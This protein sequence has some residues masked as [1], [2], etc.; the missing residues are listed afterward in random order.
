VLGQKH[1]YVVLG[2]RASRRITQRCALKRKLEDSSLLLQ[3]RNGKGWHSSVE[4]DRITLLRLKLCFKGIWCQ[5]GILLSKTNRQK[6]KQ[7]FTGQGAISSA[8]PGL[9]T[10]T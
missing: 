1:S 4:G 2:V 7:V 6:Q 5:E 8:R 9:E 3:Y 10:S